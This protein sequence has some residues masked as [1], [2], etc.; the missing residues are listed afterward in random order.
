MADALSTVTTGMSALSDDKDARRPYLDGPIPV[1]STFD[2]SKNDFKQWTKDVFE[3]LG[4]LRKGVY[5]GQLIGN[6]VWSQ[7]RSQNDRESWV[8]RDRQLLTYLKNCLKNTDVYERI[9]DIEPT[10]V[11]DMDTEQAQWVSAPTEDLPTVLRCGAAGLALEIATAKYGKFTVHDNM[12]TENLIQ[13]LSSTNMELRSSLCRIGLPMKIP[14]TSH[15]SYIVRQSSSSKTIAV[16]SL[17]RTTLSRW[18]R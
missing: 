5:H 8:F 9:S 18:P 4:T 13:A 3:H 17:S 16:R 15:A 7:Q 1:Q 11:V 14:S 10:S 12:V 6:M 2:P